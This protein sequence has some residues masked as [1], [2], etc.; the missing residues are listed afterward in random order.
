[1]KNT[2][3]NNIHH[4]TGDG[5]FKIFIYVYITIAFLVVLYPLVYV[6]SA[7]FSSVNAVVS[8]RVWLWPVDVSFDAYKAVF[9]SK[10]LLMGYKNSIIYTALGTTVNLLVTIL[11]AYPLSRKDLKGRNLFTGVF[12]FTMLF[13]GGMIATY[14]VVNNLR[15]INTIW[16]IILPGAISVWNMIIMRTY[17]QSAIPNELYE[18]ASLDGCGDFKFLIMIVLP[19]SKTIIAVIAMY[20]A[21]GHWNSYFNPMLYLTDMKKYPLQM[22][23]R[24]ILILGQMESDMIRA[25]NADQFRQGLGQLLKYSVIVVSSVPMLLVY[26]CIQKYFVKGVM[27]GAIKG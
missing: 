13:S 27:I 3:K 22:V 10:N 9:K 18:S 15:L 24:E 19:L 21:V 2:R 4:T 12:A 14:M 25:M 16:A 5:I 6:L 8:G 17:F 26:A 11:A 23:L 1:M 20:Y 7:S